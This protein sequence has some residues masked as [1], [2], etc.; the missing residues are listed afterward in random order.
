LNREPRLSNIPEIIVTP[1]DQP[2]TYKR[3]KDGGAEAVIIKP[4][5]IDIMEKTLRKVEM[6]ELG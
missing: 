2:Q 1:D 4:V 3:T 6:I 5:M